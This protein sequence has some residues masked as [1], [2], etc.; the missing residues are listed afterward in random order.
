MIALPALAVVLM[1]GADCRIEEQ[2]RLYAS[3]IYSS[4]FGSSAA[5]HRDVAVVGD[6]LDGRVRPCGA[7]Y[8]F[9]LSGGR[10]AKEQEL[11]PDCGPKISDFGTSVAVSGQVIAIGAANAPHVDLGLGR[12]FVY[13]FDGSSWILEAEL[14]GR[15]PDP[16]DPFP[17]SNQ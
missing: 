16:G 4:S 9:R 12:V 10:W 6:S 11:V 5:A 15:E 7:A 2:Q 8:V 17:G 1:V 13:R 3:R 14:R